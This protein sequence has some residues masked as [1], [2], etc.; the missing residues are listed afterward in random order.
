[1]VKQISKKVSHKDIK[2]PLQE[3]GG[4]EQ[5]ESDETARREKYFEIFLVLIL[6]AFGIYHSILY[7]GHTIVPNPDFPAFLK[8]GRSILSF[9][10]PSSFKRVPVLGIFQVCISRFIGGEYSDLTAGWLLNAILHPLNLVLLWF[11]GRKIVGK[12]AIWLALIAIIN[13]QILYLLT[14]PI[15]ETTL[16][17]FV[18]LSFYFIFRRSSWSYLFASI[19]SMVRY[20]GA[21][22]I[23]AAF[24]MDMIYSKT[25][26]ERV[27]AFLYSGLAL[28]PLALWIL[29]TVVFWKSQNAG[30][31][32]DVFSGSYTE[33]FDGSLENRI[34]FV[35]H[36][37]ALWRVGFQ[38]LLLPYSGADRSFTELLW[39]VNKLFIAVTFLCGCIYGLIRRKWNILALLLFLVPYFLVH[40]R[41]P[42]PLQ[43]YYSPIAWM[44]LLICWFGL[45]GIWKLINGNGRIP[46]RL[47]IVLQALLLGACLVWLVGLFPDFGKLISKSGKSASLSYVAIALAGTITAFRVYIYKG[48]SLLRELLIMSLVCLVI[49]SN[50]FMV[51][52]VVGD[53]QKNKEFKLLA[54]WYVNNAKAGEKLGVYMVPVVRLYAQKCADDIVA[55]PEAKNPQDFVKAC[56]EQDIDYVVWATREGL[57]RQHQGYLLLGLDKNIAFLSK[58]GN[59]GP[60]EF[61]GQVGWKRGYVNIFRLHRPAELIHTKPSNE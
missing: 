52:R 55:L 41:W 14:E 32:F 18:L 26:R 50:Q 11:A 35:P 20:E 23:L 30:H 6:L 43:R 46:K 57:S 17:F 13:P 5:F 24:V 42:W 2:Q 37:M 49:V 16:M 12:S 22:L 28:I 8:T 29:G 1:M 51:V 45:Q 56:Y 47:I 27:R 21:A 39:G 61:I 36:A 34:G 15:A 54:Q 40:S 25:N 3:V 10:L 48:S 19:A 53:G 59:I 31:Y 7:F 9:Q 4:L 60:Y 38:S 33:A 58:P 44:V